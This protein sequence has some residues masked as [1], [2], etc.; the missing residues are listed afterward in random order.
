LA[1][2]GSASEVSTEGWDA[3]GDLR[4]RYLDWGGA[5]PPV[6]A[7]HGLA[8]SGHW[9]DLVAP[10]L[11]DRYRVIAPDQR[12]H[13]KTT[14]SASG[15]YDWQ[16]LASDVVGLMDRLGL[17]QAA[18]LGHSWG[19]HVASN[20]AAR[21]PDR[22]RA[23][24]MIDG[25]FQTSRLLPGASWEAFKA[26][27][28]PRDVSGTRQQFLDRLRTQLADCWN[29]DVERIVQTM[30]YEDAEG[31]IHDILHPDNHAQVMRTMWDEPPSAILPRIRC[32]TLI[33]P[34]GPRADRA[35]SD[36]ARRR[37]EMVEAAAG[38]LKNGRVH[39][40]SETIHDIGYHKPQELARVIGR[41][42]A[43]E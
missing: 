23:L 29:P 32:R 42:L 12:G 13:G 37:A 41:F 7:L 15:G 36:F 34:A 40:I 22:V 39:W 6:V 35:G 33:V 24:V 21:F 16:T 4:V 38:A 28:V 25:G 5:G 17:N 27:A 31:Q 10:H 3:V 19:G 14:Q 9:Y 11:R 18:V 30:V 2:T 43:E 20:V 26:R 8:S 1:N